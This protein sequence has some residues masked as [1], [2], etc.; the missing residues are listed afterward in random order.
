MTSD[1]KD[2]K[3]RVEIES[4]H[5]VGFYSF[6][7]GKSTNNEC[8][9]CKQNLLSPSPDDLQKGNFNINISIGSCGHVYH[10]TCILA[11]C[12]RDN[13]CPIDETLWIFANEIVHKYS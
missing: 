6:E 4:L 8:Y 2:Y 7:A 3:D 11:H 10:K 9:L 5:I 1:I 13:D 12:A